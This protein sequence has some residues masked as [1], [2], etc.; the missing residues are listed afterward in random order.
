[1][2]AKNGF[3]LSEGIEECVF[4]SNFSPEIIP[5]GEVISNLSLYKSIVTSLPILE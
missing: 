1:M 4:N 2:S 3:L 5:P